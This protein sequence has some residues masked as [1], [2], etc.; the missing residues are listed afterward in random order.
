[1]PIVTLKPGRE[2]S[3]LR[4]H[5]WIFSGAIA[6][7]QGQPASGETVAVVSHQGAPPRAG[8]FFSVFANCSSHVD[9]RRSPI[10]ADFLRA[11][12]DQSLGL[13]LAL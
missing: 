13:R 7:V 10:D 1:M 2:K 3:L 11:R 8:G 9:F 4:R 6:S 12:L 5:P